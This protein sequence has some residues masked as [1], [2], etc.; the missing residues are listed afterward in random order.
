VRLYLIFDS[1]AKLIGTVPSGVQD[2][3]TTLPGV[4][5]IPGEQSEEVL[6]VSVLPR[7][8]PG[9]TV[10]EVEVPREL[11]GLSEVELHEALMS[12]QVKPGEA[13]L[14]RPEPGH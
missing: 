5:A 8:L 4:P 13:E 9:Q 14:V 10:H 1:R 2:V 3:K 7:P 11:E 6:Q 12:Y